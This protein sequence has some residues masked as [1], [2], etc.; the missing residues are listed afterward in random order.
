MIYTDKANNLYKSSVL[1]LDQTNGIIGINQTSQTYTDLSGTNIRAALEISGGAITMNTY[2]S[3][4]VPGLYLTASNVNAGSGGRIE[5]KDAV[6][7]KGW[8]IDNNANASNH[9]QIT[10]YNTN[11]GSLC[12]DFG[13]TQNVGIGTVADNSYKLKV[14]GSMNVT[15]TSTVSGTG[16]SFMIDHPD[17]ALNK[18]H[19]L[20]H[21]CVEGP[22]RGDTLYRW[23]MNTTNKTLVQPLPSYSPYLNENWQ[24]IVSAIDSF[25]RGYV[26]LSACETF[27]TLTTNEEGTYSVLGIATRKDEAAL[28]FDKQGIEFVPVK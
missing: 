20:R 16:K 1:N 8:R 28:A 23:T 19:Y 12:M 7:N 26:T 3:D 14:D 9:L 21:S 17:P 2:R 10:G 5:F 15:G 25:G 22:T 6:N 11:V 13:T 27:F 18:T 4:S 24:F